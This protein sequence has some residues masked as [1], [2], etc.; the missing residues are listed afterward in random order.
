MPIEKRFFRKYYNE[1]HLV[2]STPLQPGAASNAKASTQ[3]FKRSH[4][5]SAV[6]APAPNSGG[7]RRTIALAAVPSELRKS[8]L[9]H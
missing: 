6:A 3:S 4:G 5:C 9:K 8:I 2:D 1:A 7:P